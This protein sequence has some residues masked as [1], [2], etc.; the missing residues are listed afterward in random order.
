MFQSPKEQFTTTGFPRRH[1]AAIKLLSIPEVCIGGIPIA[2]TDVATSARL[3]IDA[4]LA[5]R[6]TGRPPLVITSAD[7]H[8]ISLCARDLATRELFLSTDLIHAEDISLLF[9]SR[10]L[11]PV[12]LP[13]RIEIARLFHAAAQIAE[14]RQA[15]FYFFGGANALILERAVDAILQ[16]YPTLPISGYRSGSYAAD[17]ESE[18]VEGINAARPDILWMGMGVPADQSFAIRNRRRLCD[19]GLIKT[20]GLLF[21]TL[22]ETRPIRR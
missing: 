19:V 7:R 13:E 10:T 16:L 8:V 17:S 11:S 9:A 15:K 18:V 21:Q 5:H 14:K 6:D 22:S 3:M 2:I 12:R 4:A 20:S 1:D